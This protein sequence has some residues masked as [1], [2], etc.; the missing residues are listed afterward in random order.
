MM[1]Q[2]RW[3]MT[4]VSIRITQ[5]IVKSLKQLRTDDETRDTPLAGRKE[6]LGQVEQK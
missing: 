4:H 6:E 2:H 5:I 3:S 1:P